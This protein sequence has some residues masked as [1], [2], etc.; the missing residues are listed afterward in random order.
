MNYELPMSPFAQVL[1]SLTSSSVG[2]PRP[3]GSKVENVAK[4]SDMALFRNLFLAV[5]PLNGKVTG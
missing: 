4:R 2:R 1:Y 3:D 5:R